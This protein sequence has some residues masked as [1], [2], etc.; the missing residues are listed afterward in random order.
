M[1]VCVLKPKFNDCHLIVNNQQLSMEIKHVFNMY[2]QIIVYFND[3]SMHIAITGILQEGHAEVTLHTEN[4]SEGSNSN[5]V[6]FSKYE[7][8]K[9]F[10]SEKSICT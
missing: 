10:S 4:I 5:K 7:Q 6:N 2:I 3:R 9:E 8:I 1:K